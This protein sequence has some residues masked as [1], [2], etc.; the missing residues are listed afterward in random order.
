MRK[1]RRLADKMT[2]M[3]C[4]VLIA[5]SAFFYAPMEV[6]AEGNI[7]DDALTVSN[8]ASKKTN[9]P[10]SKMTYLGFVL[11]TLSFFDSNVINDDNYYLIQMD[12]FLNISSTISSKIQGPVLAFETTRYE[13]FTFWNVSDSGYV[14]SINNSFSLRGQKFVV[15]GKCLKDTNI[16]LH[17]NILGDSSGLTD[18]NFN[19]RCV[20]N[21]VVPLSDSEA[22]DY[23]NGY[24]AGYSD[25]EQVGYGN[26]YSQGFTDG[27]ASVDTDAIYDEAF[28]AGKD[29][30]DTQSYYDAGYQAGYQVAYSEGYE[31]GYDVG[32]QRAMDRIENWG[33]DTTVYPILISSGSS[34]QVAF[35]HSLG[36]DYC[37]PFDYHCFSDWYGLD[38]FNV[39]ANHTYKFEFW[40]DSISEYD[41]DWVTYSDLQLF[42]NIG[43]YKYPL[44]LFKSGEDNKISIYISGDRMSDSMSFEA[45]FY[46]VCNLKADSHIGFIQLV[47]NNLNVAYYDMGP[48]GDTQNH[49]ANQTDQ[50]TNGYD[51]SKGNQVNSDFSTG[52]NDYE[53][54]ENSLF[55][56]AT[57]GMKDFTF[58]DFESVPAMITGM[59]FIGSIMGSWFN[60][61][62]G[63]SGVGIVLSILFSVI[64]VAM[65]LG[66][67]R[68][69]QSRGGKN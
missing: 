68:W 47:I 17:F 32:Y 46:G 55:A 21:S 52:L 10:N 9:L 66:L 56:T 41:D 58:F 65:V 54:A 69:Y 13:P 18:L 34:S 2:I 22:N 45:V 51:D 7:L 19:L 50:L 44:S 43:G 62:G 11:G 67:Y 61:A 38:N 1:R 48:S 4:A 16:A 42:A 63:A 31:S 30:V 39:D 64:L 5:F 40:F 3:V 29:S 23:Q 15:L 33:A 36:E 49:I 28:Q 57:T 20:L 26:G 27:E 53:T 59:S 60:Q 8:S 24:N 25:G 14:S 35:E 12:V 6:K 37:F